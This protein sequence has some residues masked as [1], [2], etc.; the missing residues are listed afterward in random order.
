MSETTSAS[1]EM[2][3]GQVRRQS[4]SFGDTI[5]IT[6]QVE[7]GS[8]LYATPLS[9]QEEL[10]LPVPPPSGSVDPPPYEVGPVRHSRCVQ[11]QEPYFRV[12]VTQGT[13][14]LPPSNVAAWIRPSRTS[15]QLPLRYSSGLVDHTS[16]IQAVLD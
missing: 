11:G 13:R 7:V 4:V 2:E 3:E 5:L 15:R 12:G 8:K 16:L 9:L 14:W 10:P 1:S 6:F